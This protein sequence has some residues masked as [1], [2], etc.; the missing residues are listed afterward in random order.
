M[1]PEA[2]STYNF[3]RPL[4]ERAVPTFAKATYPRKA[5]HSCPQTI[6]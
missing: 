4:S 1:D 3:L 5:F 6:D 2:V